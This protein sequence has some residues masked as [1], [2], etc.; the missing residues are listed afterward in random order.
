MA[1]T[2]TLPSTIDKTCPTCKRVFSVS[3][4]L[5][6]KRTYCGKKCA[7]ANP[8][9]KRKIVAA[10]NKTFT[11]KYGMHPMK[12]DLTKENL[13][14]AVQKKYGVDWISQSKGWINK[15]K[16]TKLQKYGDENYLNPKKREETC[17]ERYGVTNYMMTDEYKER[18]KTTCLLKYG[19]PHASMG[20]HF[21][22]EHTKTMFEKFMLHPDFVNFNPEFTVNEYKGV[23]AQNYSFKCKRCG[24]IKS[25]SIDDG[26]YP[27]CPSCDKNNC[28]TFQNEIYEYIKSLI[29]FTTDIKLNNRTI[30][31]PKELDIVIPSLNFA[32]EC[33]GVL[34]HSELFGHK[35]KIYHLNKTSACIGRGYRL[36]HIWDNEWRTKQ[37]IVKS[38]IAALLNKPSETVFGRKCNVREI[39][40]RVCVDFLN[41]NHL[42][43]TD[44]SSIKIG[45]FDDADNLISVMTFLKSRFDKKIQYEMGR[46]C[47]KIGYQIHGGASKLFSYFLK[48]YRPSSIVSYSD[49]RYFDGQLYINLGFK[50]MG[51][52]SPN[53]Y[54][55]IDNYQTT[56]NRIC[57]QKHKLKGKLKTFDVSLS[58]WENMKN[59]GYD[60]IWDC[61]NGKWVW[62]IH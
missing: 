13:K 42:Q 50:F 38:V 29:G 20:K 36:I 19:F 16:Q 61:G 43:G 49:R 26:K 32:V 57:W 9:V 28:S 48:T 41:E 21:R 27:S 54:Y 23:A 4:Y 40:S 15:V 34:W 6:N 24:T 12:T 35:N 39:S 47:N 62:N 51:N 18:Y 44:H 58:E 37:K 22:M 7:N 59:N 10:Q 53:G 30:L 5:R 60:R 11:K 3:Y 14:M 46:F 56:Q 2:K 52:T 31:S 1:R 8:E 25:Y 17:R 45:L 55:I 33:D